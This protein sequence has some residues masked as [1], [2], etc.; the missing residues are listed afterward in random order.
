LEPVENRRDAPSYAG[1]TRIRFEGL[2]LPFAP[3]QPE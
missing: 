2:G 1:I 3:S